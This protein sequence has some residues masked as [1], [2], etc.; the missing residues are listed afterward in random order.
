MGLVEDLIRFLMAYDSSIAQDESD[1]GDGSQLALHFAIVRIHY[2]FLYR[3]S[4]QSMVV[5]RL[6][7]LPSLPTLGGRCSPGAGHGVHV[8]AFLLLTKCPTCTLLQ[9]T[10]SATQVEEDAGTSP[11]I[12]QVVVEVASINGR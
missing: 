3:K 7:V 10:V 6:Q 12:A 5:K 9:K 8:V 11:G 2:I 1:I 4:C